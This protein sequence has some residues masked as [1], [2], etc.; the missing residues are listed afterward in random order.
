MH[1]QFRCLAQH[2]R[3]IGCAD[4]YRGQFHPLVQHP[5]RSLRELE[6]WFDHGEFDEL[7]CLDNH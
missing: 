7:A 4:N 2:N 5:H 3:L 1:R 6:A